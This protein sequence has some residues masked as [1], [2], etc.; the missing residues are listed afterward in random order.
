MA[1]S[2]KFY[3]KV[4]VPKNFNIIWNTFFL[5]LF[6]LVVL[7][8]FLLQHW[9]SLKHSIVIRLCISPIS[10]IFFCKLASFLFFT[11]FFYIID[12]NFRTKMKTIFLHLCDVI[13][14]EQKMCTHSWLNQR[15]MIRTFSRRVKRYKSSFLINV[16]LCFEK[17]FK[18]L[19]I[20]IFCVKNKTNLSDV[21]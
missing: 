18:K 4:I 9:T 13:L 3:W 21:I 1:L 5:R 6:D 14:E 19:L 10:F 20:V 7:K 16:F 15:R 17:I 2:K 11:S 8:L 12:P